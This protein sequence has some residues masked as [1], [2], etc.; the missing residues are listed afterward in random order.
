MLWLMAGWQN[1]KIDTRTSLCA[2]SFF[3][4]LSATTDITAL[5]SQSAQSASKNQKSQLSCQNASCQIR[6]K[7][8]VQADT[9]PWENGKNIRK[10]SLKDRTWRVSF[11]VQQGCKQV[12]IPCKFAGDPDIALQSA[13][14][15]YWPVIRTEKRC[16]MAAGISSAS[17][18][19]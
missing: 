8:F 9:Q 3:L 5:W 15:C 1:S 11:T 2:L 6:A 12:M 14:L 17:N 10:P 18:S 4:H 13:I 16:D 7:A 19:P